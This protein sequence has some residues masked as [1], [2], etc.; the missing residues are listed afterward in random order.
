MSE[1]KILKPI[2]LLILLSSAVI[3]LS[4]ISTTLWG[5]KPEEIEPS[6]ELVIDPS[7]TVM[8]FGM[9]NGIPNPVLKEVF[10]LVQ[11]S[12]LDKSLS[13]F[14]L[15]KDEITDSVNKKLALNTES[16]SKNWVKIFLKFAL[17]ISFMVVVFL[18][19][20][21]GKIN[22]KNR[23]YFYLVAIAIFGVFLGSDPNPMGTVKDAIVLLASKGVIFPPRL[24]ALTVFLLLVFIAN[25]FIC[26]WGCH[27]GALQDLIFRLNRNKKDTKAFFKQYKLPFAVTN[28]I[29]IVFF[30]VFTIVAFLWAF[31]AVEW[32]DPFKIYN[33]SKIKIIGW[34]FLGL[35]LIG[36]LFVYRPWCHL[37]CPFGLAG[38]LVEKLAIF[39]IK[40]NYDT[41]ISCEACSKACPSTVMDSILKQDKTIPDCFSC[42]VC[43]EVCPTKSIS[44]STGK[45][46]NVPIGKFVN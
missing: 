20:R 40:V 39:K 23:K 10:G 26:S 14:G 44:F 27:L 5:G 17:W 18:L 43:Q 29:R 1:Q 25:K 34:I 8:E 2:L 11:R 7:M 22:A 15:N 16:E 45:R 24:I 21:K 6:A 46:E 37:F 13:E 4:Y 12:D 3:L 28:T 38:W 36:S 30:V 35:T 9:M 41:C 31:D 33:P 42:G 32:I 19:L